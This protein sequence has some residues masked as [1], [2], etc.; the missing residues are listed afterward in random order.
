MSEGGI[1]L[2]RDVG[3]TYL[4][5][6]APWDLGTYLALTGE[7]VGAADAVFCGYGRPGRVIRRD[8]AAH[9]ASVARR[10]RNR[11]VRGADTIQFG[12]RLT[13]RFALW[14]DDAFGCATAE[15][16]FARLWEVPVPGPRAA[17]ADPGQ[18]ES[19]NA[20]GAERESRAVAGQALW[21]ASRS[22]LIVET[23]GKKCAGGGVLG[24]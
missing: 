1:G 22:A 12:R 2:A 7:R 21:P 11:T 15:E 9:R 4:L 16:I 24:M 23:S 10:C 6:R 18:N 5:S 19:L 17:A 13:R 8:R 20:V 3:R 14:I